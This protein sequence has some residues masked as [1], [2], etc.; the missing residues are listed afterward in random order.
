[1][2]ISLRKANVIQASINDAIK[3][4]SFE[5]TVRINEFENPESKIE[6]ARAEFDKNLD[7]KM[8]LDLVLYSI[9]KSVSSAN[10]SSGI[11]GRL[12]DAARIEKQIQLLTGLSKDRV[13][14]S[15]SV[16]AGKLEKIKARKDDAFYGRDADVAT[17]IFSKAD[18][19]R[20]KDSLAALRKEKQRIQDEILELNVRTEITLS[21]EEVAILKADNIV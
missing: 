10:H 1:M 6:E 20:F 4:L 5:T 7:R 3:A 18:I 8:D 16:I 12:A 2:K 14:E 13:R 17:S 19:G 11:D 15:S 9:R 21:D